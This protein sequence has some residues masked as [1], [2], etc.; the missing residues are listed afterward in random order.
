MGFPYPFLS[1]P[2]WVERCR[3]ATGFSGLLRFPA[4]L[5]GSKFDPIGSFWQATSL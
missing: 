3:Y 4:Y 5:I 2:V 1:D